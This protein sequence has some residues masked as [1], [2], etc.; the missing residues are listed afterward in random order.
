MIRV[1]GMRSIR[2]KLMLAVLSTTVLA[3]LMSAVGW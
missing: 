3:L 2:H 1:Q